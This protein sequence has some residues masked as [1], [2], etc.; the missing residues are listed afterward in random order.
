[1]LTLAVQHDEFTDGA[2]EIPSI[3]RQL[4]MVEFELSGID[5]EPDH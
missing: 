4:L 3:V 5:I 2:V 1:M